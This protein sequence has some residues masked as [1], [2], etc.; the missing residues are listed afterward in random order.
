MRGDLDVEGRRDRIAHEPDDL[1][2]LAAQLHRVDQEEAL[3][4]VEAREQVEPQGPA[5]EHG[6]VGG[7][8]ELPGER[9]G[10]PHADPLVPEEDV[11]E[12]EHERACRHARR[13]PN[14]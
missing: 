2:R 12:P 11:A 3:H 7:K 1:A 6:D 4:A 5:L 8:A 13:P 10:H 9:L 14:L